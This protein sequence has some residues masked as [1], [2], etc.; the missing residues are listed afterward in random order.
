MLK[1]GILRSGPSWTPPDLAAIR[2]VLPDDPT[3]ATLSK[4]ARVEG[5]GGVRFSQTMIDGIYV[6]DAYIYRAAA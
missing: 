3:I 1:F 5:L 2:L 4:A 6:D